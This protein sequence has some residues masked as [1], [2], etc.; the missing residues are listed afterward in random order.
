MPKPKRADD[1]FRILKEHDSQFQIF[2]NKGKGS[3]RMIFHPNIDG[4]RRSFP[5]PYHKGKDLQKG[6]LRAMI[7]RFNLPNDI[8]G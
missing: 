1:V 6:Y 5:I 3:H 7:R 2:V 8:F 4:E